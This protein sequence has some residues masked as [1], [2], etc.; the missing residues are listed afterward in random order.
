V[1]LEYKPKFVIFGENFF[2]PLKKPEQILETSE[3][4]QRL[5]VPLKQSFTEED[6]KSVVRRLLARQPARTFDIAG[7]RRPL[8]DARHSE[9]YRQFMSKRVII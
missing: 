9:E 1:T 5:S 6:I 8:D 7:H 3:I 4:E 2:E